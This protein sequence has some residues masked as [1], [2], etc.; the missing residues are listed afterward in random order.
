MFFTSDTHFSHSNI[1]KYSKRPYADVK[2]MDEALIQNWNKKVSNSDIIYHLGDFTFA[3][4]AHILLKRLNGQ[5][6]LILGNHDKRPDLR[7]GWTSIQHYKE[8]YCTVAGKKQGIILCHYAMRVWNKSHHGTWMLYGHSHGTLPDDPTLLSFDVGV[9][10]WNYEPLHVSE[11]ERI[12]RKK[13]PK[14]SDYHGRV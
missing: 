11:I 9:D 3:D 12:M 7:D 6:H 1:I 5:K 2:D 14:P 10:C 4:N 8:V 13:T